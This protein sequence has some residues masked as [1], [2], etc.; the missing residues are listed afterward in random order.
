MFVPRTMIGPLETVN[1]RF[2][3]KYNAF[4]I[5]RMG[6]VDVK[7]FA[8]LFYVPPLTSLFH[9]RRDKRMKNRNKDDEWARLGKSCSTI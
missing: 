2:P 5:A 9:S 3:R 6:I 7:N 1:P 4:E 8:R